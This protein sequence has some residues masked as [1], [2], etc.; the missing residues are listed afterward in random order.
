MPAW[1]PILA[2]KMA[3]DHSDS[4]PHIVVI[5][6]GIFSHRDIKYLVFI[7]STLKLTTFI[8][9]NTVFFLKI[10]IYNFTYKH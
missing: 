8:K 10:L 1:K 6:Q 5:E 7:I 9:S 2:Y 4:V 3:F